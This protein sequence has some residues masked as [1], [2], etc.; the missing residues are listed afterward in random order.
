MNG[1]PGQAHPAAY[2]HPTAGL[3][4]MERTYSCRSPVTTFASVEAFTVS[5]ENCPNRFA[6]KSRLFSRFSQSTPT[7]LCYQT[8][9]GGHPPAV[10]MNTHI[11]DVLDEI[12]FALFKARNL[13]PN[14][15]LQAAVDR[16]PAQQPARVS[17]A[18][19]SI[20]P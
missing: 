2:P 14:A 12:V 19:F 17:F 20:R 10:I 3:G 8:F 16:H 7:D 5:I 15:M 1:V 6:I 9:V 13:F 4:K 11:I 18:L